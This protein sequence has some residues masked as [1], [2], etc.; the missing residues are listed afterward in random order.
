MSRDEKVA[1]E[2]DEGH[3]NGSAGKLVRKEEGD[4]RRKRDHHVIVLGVL[5]MLD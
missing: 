3:A 5:H 1:S 4:E 2:E